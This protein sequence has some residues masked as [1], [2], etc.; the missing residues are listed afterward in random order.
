MIVMSIINV[1]ITT[2]V[3]GNVQDL[4]KKE[5]WKKVC[6]KIKGVYTAFMA[7][8]NG[9]VMKDNKT[10]LNKYKSIKNLLLKTTYLIN[11]NI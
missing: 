1:I 10:F 2:T 9:A 6:E 4:E 7:R 5:V 11:N 8:L 3:P